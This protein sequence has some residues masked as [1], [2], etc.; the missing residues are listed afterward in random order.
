MPF[1]LLLYGKENLSLE[2]SCMSLMAV[3]YVIDLLDL[4]L[5]F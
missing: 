2:E 1:L 5:N 4:P 3:A